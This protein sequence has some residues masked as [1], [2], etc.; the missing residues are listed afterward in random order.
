MGIAPRHG[1]AGNNAIII[2]DRNN[3]TITNVKFE[4]CTTGVRIY[5]STNIKITGNTF[6]KLA[7]GFGSALGVAIKDSSFI[8]VEDNYFGSFSGSAIAC[9]GTSNIIRGNTIAGSID[10]EGSSNLVLDNTNRMYDSNN[11]EPS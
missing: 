7:P 5:N 4:K 1:D 10:L 11:N 6:T 9:N 3:I 8:L 2:T